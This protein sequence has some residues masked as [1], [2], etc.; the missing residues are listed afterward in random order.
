MAALTSLSDNELVLLLK[1]GS[2]STLTA[3]YQRYWDKLLTVATNRLDDPQEA[4]ECV[5]DVFFRLWQRRGDF[6]LSH[7]LATYLAVAVKYRVINAMD[8][9]YRLR[10]RMER[11]YSD[12]VKYQVFSAEDYLLEKELKEQIT[13]SINKLLEKCRIVFKLSREQGLTHKQIASELDIAEKTVEAHIS[14]ALKDICGN[15]AVTLPAFMAYII[16]QH[17]L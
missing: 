5:Q 16:S 12:L 17:L 3:L 4:E 8:K 13:A 9:Q 2:E 10:N 6:Q 7:S 1:E 11:S 15:L 14:K